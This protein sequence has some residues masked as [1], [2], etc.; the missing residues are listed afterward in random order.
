MGLLRYLLGLLMVAATACGSS[1]QQAGSADPM[2]VVPIAQQSS[3]AAGY[4]QPPEASTATKPKATSA[5]PAS[6]SRYA[7]ISASDRATARALASTGHSK[8][9]AGDA[10]GALRDFTAADAIIQVP[11]IR[12]EM[13]QAQLQLGHT[14]AAC[15]TLHSVI[16]M[17]SDPHEP[18]VFKHAR[19]QAS[20]LAQQ[21]CP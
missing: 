13:A 16:R 3:A 11:T 4:E 9:Q 5:P 8:L 7:N 21:H 1:S 17:P 20:S 14:P 18:A 12:L 10:K 19:A 6:S 2:P 15:N